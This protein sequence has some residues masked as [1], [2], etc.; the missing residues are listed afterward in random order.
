M[1]LVQYDFS[2]VTASWACNNFFR[3]YLF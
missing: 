2:V 3:E 1:G